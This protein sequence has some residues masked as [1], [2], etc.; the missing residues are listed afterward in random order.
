MLL[1]Q[2]SH[3]SRGNISCF[4]CVNIVK[5]FCFDGSGFGRVNRIMPNLKQQ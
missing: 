5:G 2:L 1:A 3:S 4:K